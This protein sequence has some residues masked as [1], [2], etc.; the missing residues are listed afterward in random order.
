M[1]NHKLSKNLYLEKIRWV[2]QKI[3]ALQASLTVYRVIE[4][5]GQDLKPL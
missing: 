1:A 4:K 5:D 2:V 3:M